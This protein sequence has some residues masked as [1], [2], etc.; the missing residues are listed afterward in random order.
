MSKT[1][2]FNLIYLILTCIVI[3]TIAFA[4]FYFYIDKQL[5]Y[6]KDE[7]TK[8]EKDIILEPNINNNATVQVTTKAEDE[9]KTYTKLVYQYYY[10]GTDEVIQTTSEPPYYLINKNKEQIEEH[11]PDWQL[12]SFSDKK[13]VLRKSISIPNN[14]DEF[15]I[16]AFEN[17]ICI[18]Y[19]DGTIKEITQTNISS[20]SAEEQE[21]IKKGIKVKS[22]EE[23]IK[24]LQDYTS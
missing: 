9:I 18:Y 8:L 7:E 23:L 14:S 19:G 15:V 16:G 21:L 11:Y 24:Y 10:E 1:K 22:E 4:V 5:S 20:L 17:Y 2:K 3:S 6:P 12:V 13:V